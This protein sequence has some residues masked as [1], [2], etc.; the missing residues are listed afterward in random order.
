MPFPAG[1]PP[2]PASSRRSLRFYATGTAS[3]NFEDNAFLFRDANYALVFLGEGVDGQVIVSRTVAGPAGNRYSVQLIAPATGGPHALSA[4]LSDR[5]LTV[6]LATTV[7]N[8]L[9]PVANTATL[10][11]AAIAGIPGPVFSAVVTG[12]GASPLTHIDGPL[13]FYF[14]GGMPVI[15]T[16]FVPPGGASTRAVAGDTRITGSPAGGGD[17]DQVSTIGHHWAHT[18]R[19][20]ND[21]GASLTYS[22]DGVNTHGFIPA[23]TVEVVLRYRYEGGICVSGTAAFTIEA[24]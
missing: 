21:G 15:P 18:I 16:P 13:S 23:T 8:D 6:S 19:I 20:V 3:A 5:L 2:R 7:T 22:F 14:G 24:W 4:T 11:A 10:V 1:W 17:Y 9:D 12:T